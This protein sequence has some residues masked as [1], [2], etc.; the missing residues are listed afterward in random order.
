MSAKSSQ[1]VEEDHV[2]GQTGVVLEE[3][4]TFIICEALK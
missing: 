4:A 1:V 3:K 2:L